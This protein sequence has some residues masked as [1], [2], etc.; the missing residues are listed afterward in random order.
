M[1]KLSVILFFMIAAV[2]IGCSDVRRHPGRDYMPDMRYSRAYETYSPTDNLKALGINYTGMPVP[3]TV[4]RGEVFPFHIPKDAEG[5]STNYV[6]SRQVAN[7]L[8]RPN[9]EL[10]KEAERMYLINCGVCHGSKLDG[11]GPL[12]NEGNGPYPAAPK[13]LIGDPVVSKMPDGQMFYSITYGKGQMG[14]YG[15]QTST[16]QRWMIIHYINS[17]QA[18]PTEAPAKAGSDST[19]S[20]KATVVNAATA[21]K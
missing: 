15:P 14:P 1:K 13:N 18:S 9:A 12:Y 16:T 11:N 3:G 10:M 5:D 20:A 17:K 8:P 4:K 2:L 19:T 6:D 21:K 7:P